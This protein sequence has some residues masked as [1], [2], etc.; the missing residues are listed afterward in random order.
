V[1]TASVPTRPDSLPSRAAAAG[2]GPAAA[3][4]VTIGD[5]VPS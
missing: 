4:S 1:I 2:C 5:S 3:G